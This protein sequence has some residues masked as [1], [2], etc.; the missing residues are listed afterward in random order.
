MG[1]IKTPKMGLTNEEK[2]MLI[3]RWMFV[4][5]G[6]F[7]STWEWRMKFVEYLGVVLEVDEKRISKFFNK[8]DADN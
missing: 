7:G 2:L 6:R 1:L 3:V 4:N 8:D 5:D